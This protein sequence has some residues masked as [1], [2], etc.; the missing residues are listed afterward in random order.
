[1]WPACS[2]AAARRGRGDRRH[3]L[4]TCADAQCMGRDPRLLRR[5]HDEESSRRAR[6]PQP[7]IDR[8]HR[9]G[10][11]ARPDRSLRLGPCGL[12]LR[13]SCRGHDRGLDRDFGSDGRGRDQCQRRCLAGGGVPRPGR[14]AAVDRLG[15]QVGGLAAR[16]HG[17]MDRADEG[18]RHRRLRRRHAVPAARAGHRRRLRLGRQQHGPRRRR[19]GGLDARPPREGQG[20]G[21]A[22]ALLRSRPRRRRWPPSTSARRCS[23][24]TSRA[25]RTAAAR[26]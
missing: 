10:V 18:Q 17:G 11:G 13:R 24:R 15:N 25:A 7:A 23:T 19:I 6:C 1:M 4:V 12:H 5:Q 22:R 26:R 21:P 8:R 3:P 14:G 20:L 9:L 16:Q 2:V